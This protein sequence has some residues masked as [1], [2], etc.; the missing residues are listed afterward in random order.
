[1]LM[2]MPAYRRDRRIVAAA[3]FGVFQRLVQVASTLLLMP[4]VLRALG[5]AHFGVWG[6]ASSLAWLVGLVDIGT[7]TAL[8]SL[9]A[10]SMARNEPHE[11]RNQVTGALGVGVCAALVMLAAA[12]VGWI[13]GVLQGSSAPYL[14][15][16]VGLALNIP[17]S[18]A[19][20]VWMALQKGYVSGFWELVQTVLSTAALITAGAFT[21]DVWVFVALVYAGLVVSNLGSLIHLLWAHPELRPVG[22]RVPTAAMREVALSGILFFVLGIATGLSFMLDNVLALQ[23]LGPEAAARMTIAVRICLSALG[24]IAVISQPLWPAFTE[25]AHK[26]DRGWIRRTL[27]RGSALLVGLAAAESLILVIYGEPLLRLWLHANLGIGRALLVAIS[28]WI[29]VHSL[30]RVPY[31]LLNGLS[32]IPFQIA[33]LSI[34]TSIAL[35]LKFGLA[36]LLGVAGILWGTIIPTLLIVI[37]AGIWRIYTW[38]DESA[39]RDGLA[40]D[41]LGSGEIANRAI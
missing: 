37:P 22:L 18:S 17:L 40:S 38:A 34:S 39:K 19:N 32:L 24:L 16:L 21:K 13:S 23:L 41:Q 20:N 30:G 11:A 12:F 9:V 31:L 15:A 1:M 2:D 4:F 28:A 33:V 6:A 36:P 14:I 8:V 29:I 26:A 5:A 3:S 35:G 7:G 25:A 27:L 10:R